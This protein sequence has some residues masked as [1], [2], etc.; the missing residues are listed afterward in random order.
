MSTEDVLLILRQ[1]IKN[2][3]P[4]SYVKDGTSTSALSGATHIAISPSVTVP[5]STA[6]RWRKPDSSG[7]SGTAPAMDPKS[8]PERFFSV[9]A[10]V[11]VWTV[12]DGTAADYM[13]QARDMPGFVS[14]TDRKAVV[15]WLEGKEVDSDKIAP[16]SEEPL[17]EDPS[18]SVTSGLP[19]ASTTESPSKSRAPARPSVKRS[20]VP[21]AADLEAVKKIRTNEV[22]L[23]DRTTVLRGA[24]VNN[25]NQ[26]KD[27]VVQ[28]KSAAKGKGSAP[29]GPS[30]QVVTPK[31]ASKK[32][33][34]FPII[35]VSS[36]PTA[37]LTLHNVK[38][39]LEEA[40][41]E[42]SEQA[43]AK[44]GKTEDMIPIYRKRTHIGPGGKEIETRIK[45]FA[46][47]SIDALAKF[48]QDPWDRVVCVMTTGQEWQF[49][50]YKWTEPRQLF[51][52]G[53]PT[54]LLQRSFSDR[55]PSLVKGIY[56]TWSNDPPNPKTKDWNVSELKIDQYK[57]HVDKSVV[58]QF[59]KLLDAWM[60]SHKPSLLL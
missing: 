12:K 18:S 50:P 17:N 32:P 14:L 56:F 60:T 10:I 51:H 33:R 47:D 27:F 2:K 22:E 6:T 13:R 49:K 9:D 7:A 55:S 37:L 45:Y 23:R 38:R 15:D 36:S 20:Y 41:Y 24:K 58:A 54:P 44:N 3:F 40:V 42:T 48:G 29:P 28:L 43:K 1:S 25:F 52:H 53:I 26:I 46:V 8:E 21:D 5:R 19:K 30:S 16:L 35:M 31:G 57:R 11:L 59:W 34:V 4:I 39:F